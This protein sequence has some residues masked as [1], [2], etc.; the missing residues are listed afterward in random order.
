MRVLG[1]LVFAITLLLFG[2]ATCMSPGDVHYATSYAQSASVPIHNARK[3]RRTV[4]R[5]SHEYEQR[6][7]PHGDPRNDQNK[8]NNDGNHGR[9]EVA[10]DATNDG[11]NSTHETRFVAEC[12][13]PTKQG[14]YKMRS[15]VYASPSQRLEPIVMVSGDLS[16]KEDVLVRVHDQCFT[17]E[18]FGSLRCDCKEQLEESLAMINEHGGVVIYLQQEGRG[19][20]IANKVAAYALQDGG[21]DTVD[22]N[23][24]LGFGDELREYY[25]VPAILSDLGIKSIKLMTNNP[26]K[27]EQLGALGVQI[28]ERVPL[29][30]QSNQYNEKYLRSKKDKMR[31]FLRDDLLAIKPLIDVALRRRLLEAKSAYESSEE[32]FSL[33]NDNL[34]S[35]RTVITDTTSTA[36]VAAAVVST[37]SDVVTEVQS[38]TNSDNSIITPDTSAAP[39][40]ASSTV[41]AAMQEQVAEA[42]N[43]AG[44]YALGR[45]SVEAAIS[46]VAAGKLVLVVDDANRENEG[47]LI[48]AAEK[49]TPQAIGFMV[50]HSS[51]VL[52][53][54]LEGSRLDA[55]HLPPMV[56]HNEDPKQTAYSVSVDY[57]HNTSTGI[58]AYDRALTFRRLVDPAALPSDFH[59]P[60]HV[61]PLRYQPG[62]VLQRA[63]H[64]EAALDLSR[65]AGLRPGGVLAEVVHDDGS[66]QVR[67]VKDLLCSTSIFIHTHTLAHSLKLSVSSE[68]LIV[69]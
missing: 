31:H 47:D 23:T 34:S 65:L 52:C 66:M 46:E 17:S 42:V 6:R 33:P 9:L 53:V 5:A 68:L 43:A 13:M 54:S 45:A 60:G 4:T 8:N 50:R 19:I 67:H 21:M 49:A 55:L 3:W 29:Q 27:M 18:V 16:N 40:A 44:G 25:A 57:R 51:G 10:Y 32:Q 37:V 12:N 26:Y 36:S 11:N 64:T 39:A 56:V 35:N 69:V 7:T 2:T 20:G 38:D 63:G 59:R 24:H 1:V 62:G 58:S 28:V 30:V 22:A 48:M 15:Y 61:F 41:D 14:F